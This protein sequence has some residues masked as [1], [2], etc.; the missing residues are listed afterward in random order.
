MARENGLSL[1]DAL[2]RYEQHLAR[3]P[4]SD[5]SRKAF[6]GDARIFSRYLTGSSGQGSSLLV[7]RITSEHI[8][9]FL[10]EQAR[11][12]VAASPKSIERRLTSL[13]VFFRW[14]HETGQI[15]LDPADSVAYKPFV[16]PLPEY[17]SDAEVSAVIQAARALAQSARL[18]MRPLTAILLVLDTGIK[19]G[20]CLNLL[21]S[22]VALDD[23]DGASIW[24]RYDKRHLQFKD[25]RLAISDECAQVVRAHIDRYKCAPEDK[26]FD[27]T[28]RNLEYIFNR[29][30][31]P[32][33][34]V[35]ALT[36]EMLRW[37]C[38]VRDYRSGLWTS[39][40]LQIRYGLSPVGWAEMLAKLERLTRSGK[41]GGEKTTDDHAE[42]PA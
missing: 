26:L 23:P 35:P 3:R 36:F 38:A 31:A 27:C 34:G 17:L 19:K 40:Q 42:F 11:G 15:A 28:G 5:N 10:A 41:L 4:L 20:E 2:L 24:V 30:I 18:E 37:T 29:K 14:L 7:A 39:E 9:G 16:D 32:Q 25:R 6:L 33:A 22:D 1:E 13:K 21:R 8:K 12:R